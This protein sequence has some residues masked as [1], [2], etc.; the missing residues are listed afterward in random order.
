MNQATNAASMRVSNRKLILNL[1]R[2][3]PVSRAELSE[4]THLTRASITQIVDE[5][6]EAGLVQ[7]CDAGEPAPSGGTP[8]RRRTLLTLCPGA[9]YVFGVCISRRR[10]R[11][12]AVDLCGT[13]YAAQEFPLA[14]LTPA[15]AADAAARLIDTQRQQLGLSADVILGIG[16]STPGPVD[17]LAGQILNPPNFTA[18][19]NVPVCEMLHSR[20]G[21]PSLLE[22]DTNARA[23]EEKYFGAAADSSGF[24]LVQIDD[25]VGSGVIIRDTLYRGTH[26]RGTEIGHTSIRYDGPVCSCGGRGCLENYLRIPALLAGSRFENWEQLAAHAADPDASRLLDTAADYLAAALVNAINLYDLEK[27]VLTGEVAAHPQPL[28]ERLNPLVSARVLSRGTVQQPPVTAG[29][30][31]SVRTAAMAALYDVFQDRG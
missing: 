9:R 12:G 16:V 14:G 10:C 6:L 3:G 8:G 26:G 5:L 30:D 29:H 17:H 19:H 18:W 27:V 21:L 31:A 15:A 11:V 25:G 2:R 4:H 28:L 23:L 7:P 1:I 22:K 24:L 20:T 13:V